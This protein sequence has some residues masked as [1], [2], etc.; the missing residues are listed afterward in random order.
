VPV[1]AL[2]D[3]EIKANPQ[4]SDRSIAKKVGCDQKWVGIKL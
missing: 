1:G 4:M 2:I 3:E